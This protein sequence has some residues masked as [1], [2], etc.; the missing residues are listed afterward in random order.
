MGQG[1]DASPEFLLLHSR[2]LWGTPGIYSG[3]MPDPPGTV[4][5][6]AGSY[7]STGHPPG[8]VVPSVDLRFF[9]CKM[10]VTVAFPYE[11]REN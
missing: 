11:G 10:E 1:Q 7:G 3:Y 2:A 9:D 6:N 5:R 8:E 4:Q